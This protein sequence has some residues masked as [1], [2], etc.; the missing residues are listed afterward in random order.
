MKEVCKCGHDK[1]RHS[2]GETSYIT[3][4]KNCTGK[5]LGFKGWKCGGYIEET[6]CDDCFMKVRERKHE[7]CKCVCHKKK[8]A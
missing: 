6:A 8:G 1:N 4:C 2:H 7:N 5:A 3:R